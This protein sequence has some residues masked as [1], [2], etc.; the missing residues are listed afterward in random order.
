MIRKKEES[1]MNIIL[2]ARSECV[3]L[4]ILLFLFYFSFRYLENEEKHSFLKMCLFALGHVTFDLITIYTVI[5][6]YLCLP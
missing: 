3:C 2:V 1:H 4:A 6:Y 5:Y